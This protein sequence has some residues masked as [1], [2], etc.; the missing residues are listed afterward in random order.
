MLSP[1]PSSIGQAWDFWHYWLSASTSASRDGSGNGEEYKG[2]GKGGCVDF[3]GAGK[4][5]RS[6]KNVVQISDAR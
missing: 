3:H 2:S 1:I 5:K 4:I 6:E